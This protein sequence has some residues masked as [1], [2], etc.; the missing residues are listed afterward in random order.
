M[1][2]SSRTFMTWART[3]VAPR[4]Q[5]TCQ[6]HLKGT[7]PGE[8]AGPLGGRPIALS[9]GMNAKAEHQPIMPPDIRRALSHA[10]DRLTVT[11]EARRIV[12]KPPTAGP[13]VMLTRRT[14]QKMMTLLRL[15]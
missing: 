1:F 10:L 13:R 9:P 4:R 11:R 8:W 3:R 2:S 15:A 5:G 12:T 14:R 6:R 7:Q